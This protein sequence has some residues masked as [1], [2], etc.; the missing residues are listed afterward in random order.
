MNFK[1]NQS[2]VFGIIFVILSIHFKFYETINLPPQSTDL[3]RQADCFTIA[4]N[5]YQNGFH[6]FKPQVHFLFEQNG[7]AAGEFPLIYF[8]SALLFKI[9]GVHYFLFKGLNL[10]IFYTGLYSLFKVSVKLTNDHLFSYILSILYFCTPVIFFYANNFLSDVSALSFNIIG[11]LFFINFLDENKKKKLWLAACCFTLAGLLKASASIFLIAIICALF[12]ELFITKTKSTYFQVINSNKIPLLFG[13]VVSLSLIVAWYLYAIGFNKSNH[14]VFFGTKAMKGWPIWENNTDGFK[15]TINYFQSI[16]VEI[17]S[18]VNLILFSI[19]ILIIVAFIKKVDRL[20]LLILF[21]L[22]IG[23]TLFIAYFWKGFQDQQYY[24]VNLIILPI[25]SILAAYKTVVSFNLNKRIIKF[26]YSILILSTLFMIYKS[27]NVYRSYYKGGWRH[28]K[29]MEVYYDNNLET[30]LTLAGIGKKEIIIS[31]S[32]GTPNGT[33][34]MLNRRG[35]SSYGFN[36]SKSFTN[37]SFE[38]KIK[39]GARFLILNDTSLLNNETI[40]HFAEQNIG[41]YKGLY[42]YKLRNY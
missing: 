17:L 42:F 25:L 29:L 28:Q 14:T 37:V 26:S 4:L 15:E 41:N 21:F 9:F 40:K 18:L 8:V 33:L 3:W 34:S 32:D 11:V 39:M 22:S 38:T 23:I 10:L 2:L 13:F 31:L 36:K 35:W 7:Y 24:L 5:Y 1:I 16:H 27:K 19:S 30:N 20:I 12:T 6:F